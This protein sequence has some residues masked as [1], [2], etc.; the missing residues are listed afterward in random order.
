MLAVKEDK[1][2]SFNAEEFFI[3]FYFF[4]P[5]KQVNEE[6]S[7]ELWRSGDDAGF[8]R[9]GASSPITFKVSEEEREGGK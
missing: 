6:I 1:D 5:C 3:L 8:V 7:P 2:Q 4:G 9:V